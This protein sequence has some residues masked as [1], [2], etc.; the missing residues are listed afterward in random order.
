MCACAGSFY[1]NKCTFNYND[2]SLL[3][4]FFFFFLPLQ[5]VINL[6]VLD[7]SY[8][9]WITHI[10]DVSGVPNLE[11]LSFKHCENLI[12]IH[13]SVGY[14]RKLKILDAASCKNLKTFP[15]IRLTLLEQLNLSHCSLVES[16]PEILGTMENVTELCIVGSPIKELPFSIVNLNRLRKLELHFCGIVQLPS[17]IVM[18]PELCLMSVSRCEGLWLYKPDKGEEWEAMPSNT[19]HLTLSYCNMSDDFFPKGLTWFAN[20][21]DLDLS[22]NNFTIVHACLKQCQFLRSLKLNDCRLIQEIVG[23][24]PNL[25]TFSAKECVSLRYMDLAG[26]SHS[27]RELILDDCVYLREIKGNLPNLNHFSAKNCTSLTSR[28]TSMLM[29]QVPLFIPI[30]FSIIKMQSRILHNFILVF[31]MCLIL[32]YFL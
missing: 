32:W 20:V 14:L 25:E 6:T 22:G 24:P 19:E 10:P 18:L 5:R 17:S 15:P 9:E 28:C 3:S 13:E 11:K 27:L 29:N 16:F 30:L 1:S 23:I 2:F 4:L 8:S 21:K 26:E 12:Q 31:G 7:F